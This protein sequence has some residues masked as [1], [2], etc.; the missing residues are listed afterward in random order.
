M[1]T[2]AG[3]K[4]DGKT[5]TRGKWWPGVKKLITRIPEISDLSLNVQSLDKFVTGLA[6]MAIETH[7]IWHGQTETG[8]QAL[9]EA[10]SEPFLFSKG[11]C[12]IEI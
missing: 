6:S 5:F 2:E 3:H 1:G 7:P 10:N 9:A 12:G 11:G 8:T 4:Y